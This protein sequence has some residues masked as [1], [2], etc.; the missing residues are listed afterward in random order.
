MLDGLLHL[1]NHPWMPWSGSCV[2]VAWGTGQWLLLQHRSI[3]PIRR[4]LADT[5][6]NLN[7][8]TAPPSSLLGQSVPSLIANTE[9]RSRLTLEHLLGTGWEQHHLHTIPN[10]LLGMG[11]FFTSVG[12]AAALFFVLRELQTDNMTDAQ[13]A[14][15]GLLRVASLKFLSSISGLGTAALFTWT[16]RRQRDQLIHSLDGLWQR[17]DAPFTHPTTPPPAPTRLTV[18]PSL[19]PAEASSARAVAADFALP[20][21]ITMEKNIDKTIQ[22]PDTDT[23]VQDD[24]PML[25]APAMV[26]PAVHARSIVDVMPM[27]ENAPVPVVQP[28]VFAQ[29]AAE[30]VRA[31]QQRRNRSPVKAVQ[32]TP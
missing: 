2:I 9:H 18:T 10:R 24:K 4:Q 31:R 30:F 23:G 3:L 7:Q 15:T 27:G 29:L 19:P 5:L 21:Q 6:Q 13:E 28:P 20:D 12:L 8:N 22:I 14:L 11:L 32:Q 1:L 26:P 25:L 17:V 16:V